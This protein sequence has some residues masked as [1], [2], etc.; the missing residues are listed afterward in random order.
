MYL[1]NLFI[2][3][4]LTLAVIS[5]SVWDAGADIYK[6]IDSQGVVHLTNEPTSGVKWRLYLRENTSSS[7]FKA[8]ATFFATQLLT[9]VKVEHPANPK[10]RHGPK[11]ELLTPG[12]HTMVY[13]DN[14]IRIEWN[15]GTTSMEFALDN[16][17]E[18]SMKILWD[19]SV[20]VHVDGVNN[21]VMHSGVKFIDKNSPQP[22]S[23]IIRKGKWEDTL[24]PADNVEW[25]QNSSKWHQ[26]PLFPSSQKGGTIE[27]F[28]K[29]V[30]PLI[31]KT[32]QVLLAL[33]I[34]G[35]INDYIFTFKIDQVKIWKEDAK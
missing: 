6:Y 31:G 17:T 25:L 27:D 9:L 21:R 16:K 22:P 14:F 26:K 18:Q 13:E 4:F 34:A 28:Q 1:R 23:V 19:E 7:T 12:K 24:V 29:S 30:D 33:E 10:K 32:V 5:A 11:T 20:Y 3:L 2:T 15:N 35:I 8:P